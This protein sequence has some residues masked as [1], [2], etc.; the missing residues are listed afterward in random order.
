MIESTG[1][2]AVRHGS[3]SGTRV[4]DHNK[5]SRACNA[6]PFAQPPFTTQASG[7]L[8]GIVYHTVFVRSNLGLR[9]LQGFFYDRRSGQEKTHGC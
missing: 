8:T 9:G 6:A 7:E 1:L 3:P 4:W 5:K 2:I